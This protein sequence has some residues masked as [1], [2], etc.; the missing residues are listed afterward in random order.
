MIPP[1]HPILPTSIKLYSVYSHVPYLGQKQ[2]FFSALV[3]SPH[4]FLSVLN[5]VGE[6]QWTD[7]ESTV[8]IGGQMNTS[9]GVYQFL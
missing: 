4:Q 7:P 5:S 6:V 2:S 9:C 3:Q 1:P 8:F